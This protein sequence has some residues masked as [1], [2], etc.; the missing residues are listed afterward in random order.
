MG[1]RYRWDVERKELVEIGIEWTPTS[2]QVAR[3]DVSYMDGLAT[4][5]GIDISSKRKRREYM[6]VAGVTDSSDFSPE[7]VASKKAA[8]ERDNAKDTRQAVGKAWWQHM[9]RGH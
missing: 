4:V 3:A 8:E 6:K 5:D 9:E 2:R 7:W 1:K